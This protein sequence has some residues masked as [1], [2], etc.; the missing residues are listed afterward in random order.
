M[1]PSV[2]ITIDW[3][4]PAYKAGGPISS[5]VNLINHLHKD[6][7]FY[8]FTGAK[9]YGSNMDF[10][11]IKTDKWLDWNGKAQVYYMSTKLKSRSNVFKILKER[12]FDYYYV[13]GI[14]SFC[15]S[16]YP[17]IWWKQFSFGKL[18]V[19]PRGM[20]HSSAL[21]VKPFKKRLFLM[22]TKFMGWYD[23]VFF[24]S[25]DAKESLQIRENFA[26]NVKIREAS[27]L[28]K[29]F[30][31]ENVKPLP[32]K[33][34]ELRVVCVS[35]ISKEKN[36]MFL[37]DALTH[38][39]R[40]IRLSFL[41]P[42]VDKKYFESFIYKLSNLPDHITTKYYGNVKP[43]RVMQILQK[44]HVLISPTLGENY[45]HAIAEALSLGLPA[46]IS[47][48]TPWIDL[49]KANA[50]FNLELNEQHF[51]NKIE[52]LYAMDEATFTKMQLASNRYIK[53]KI[54]I[55][56]LKNQYFKLFN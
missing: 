40:P 32:K 36:I 23:D 1:K 34:E 54:D 42:F 16:I 15:F 41:G 20:L 52:A 3:F 48:N 47:T 22:V 39:N 25:T 44:N 33:S 51:A 6:F 8:V 31:Y 50:G 45:G 26:A 30:D 10:T 5:I 24:H 7:D 21:S 37:L 13:Q 49:E 9:D 46:I 11:T 29:I 28:P 17:L 2:L 43:D 27:M 14:F 53:K 38:F 18:I 4:D 35:R 19:A 55:S 12:S 56:K